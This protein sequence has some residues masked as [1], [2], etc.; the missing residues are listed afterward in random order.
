MAKD[1]EEERDNHIVVSLTEYISLRA[2]S[3]IFRLTQQ[4]PTAHDT[5]PKLCLVDD[6]QWK[7]NDT[8][9]KDFLYCIPGIPNEDYLN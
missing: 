2:D 4:S 9:I 5:R 3:S 8:S 1:N 6:R 7:S